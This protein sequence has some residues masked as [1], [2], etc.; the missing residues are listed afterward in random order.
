[1]VTLYAQNE[2]VGRSDAY[3]PQS[4]APGGSPAVALHCLRQ[5]PSLLKEGRRNKE[6]KEPAL[7][8]VGLP[9]TH[10]HWQNEPH[11]LA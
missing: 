6:N 2:E 10:D 4:P 1:M 3:V 8:C 7:T 11:G 5:L 9:S